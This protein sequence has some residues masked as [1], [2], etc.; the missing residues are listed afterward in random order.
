MAAAWDLESVRSA[1]E[2][3]ISDFSAIRPSSDEASFRMQT[4]LVHAWR[5]FPF[6]DP[7]LPG[8]L[9]P[10]GWP[11]RRAYELFTGRHARWQSAA[12]SYFSALDAGRVQRQPSP[13][14]PAGSGRNSGLRRS[15]WDP[16]VDYV[17]VSVPS[18]CEYSGDELQKLVFGFGTA[19]NSHLSPLHN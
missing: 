8:E 14:P 19:G 12:G 10:A 18:G 17:N 6:V 5:K 13:T 1:Y 4:L 7:D 9:L 16:N 2:A 3:F 11:R 15:F